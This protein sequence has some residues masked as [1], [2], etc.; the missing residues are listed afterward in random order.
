MKPFA[1][2][3]SSCTPE[4]GTTA[5]PCASRPRVQGHLPE[6]RAD[7]FQKCPAAASPWRYRQQ[8]SFQAIRLTCP[9][10]LESGADPWADA[11]GSRAWRIHNLTGVLYRSTQR[12]L[13]QGANGLARA[14]ACWSAISGV[15][16]RWKGSVNSG[17][18]RLWSPG[19]P[20]VG[21]PPLV[22]LLVHSRTGV[23][24]STSPSG[25]PPPGNEVAVGS[26]RSRKI[27]GS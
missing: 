13:G 20:L 3:E 11:K 26:P 17:W 7:H 14:W 12:T 4:R 10:N 2:I 21:E 19:Q 22:P 1:V 9:P 25:L 8:P 6:V 23:K 16:R 24:K 15:A 5:S 27:E 18:M